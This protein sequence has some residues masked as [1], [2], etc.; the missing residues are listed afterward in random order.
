M[1]VLVDFERE[2]GHPEP[3]KHAARVAEIRARLV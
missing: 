2:I 3:E 1:Q